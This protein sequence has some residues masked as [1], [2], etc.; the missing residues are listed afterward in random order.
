[1]NISSTMNI[2]NM[3][4]IWN[5]INPENNSSASKVPLVDNIDSTINENYNLENYS[6]ENTNTEL[7]NIYSQ[8][9]PNYGIPIS[10]DSHGNITMPSD[11]TV[12]TDGLNSNDSNIIS[13]LKSNNSSYDNLT[14]NLLSQYTSI[15]NGTFTSNLSSILSSNPYDIYSTID[16]LGS[17]E[18]QNFNSTI[19]TSV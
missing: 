1:M 18:S 3:N 14:E 17:S 12:P 13:L 2:Y 19:N 6:G 10:Y 8:I 15:E 4:S 9:E 11:T 7:Q 5:N 16:S